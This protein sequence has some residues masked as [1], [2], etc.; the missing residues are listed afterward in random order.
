MVE[1]FLDG[2]G[3]KNYHERET[4]YTIKLIGEEYEQDF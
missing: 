4:N 3:T 2:M 1:A